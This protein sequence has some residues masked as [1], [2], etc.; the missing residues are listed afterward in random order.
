MLAPDGL[1]ADGLKIDFTARTPS[2]HGLLHHGAEW[3]V[4]LLARLLEIVADEA[5]TV[6]SEPLLV[7]HTPNPILA[8][9]IDMVRLNDLL[10]LDDPD[11]D[12]DPV[13]QMRYRAAVAR[14]AMPDH[15]I[16]TDDWCAPDLARWRAYAAIKPELGVPALYYV[17]RL[18]RTGEAL[19]DD[20]FELIRRTWAAYRRRTGLPPRGGD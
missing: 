9:S 11:P 17:D 1:D 4:D 19:L 13:P 7:A 18:D 3:G 20:D 2:G 14:A 10:R 16:D 6:R 12:V 8:P 15:P 5:R